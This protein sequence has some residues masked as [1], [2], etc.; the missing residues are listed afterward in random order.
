LKLFGRGSVS[1]DE[2]L[3]YIKGGIIVITLVYAI[4]RLPNLSE[5]AFQDYWRD[6]HGPLVAS[7]STALDISRYVQS[8]AILEN[9]ANVEVRNKNDGMLPIDGIEFYWWN[10]RDELANALATP[11]GKK[12]AKSLVEDEQKFIDFSHSTLFIGLEQIQIKGTDFSG[13]SP[14]NVV[15]IEKSHLMKGTCILYRNPK[16]FKSRQ[17][18]MLYYRGHHGPLVRSFE[19]VLRTRRY[20]Q[21][22]NIDDPLADELRAARGKMEEPPDCS[23]NA[24][25][26]RLHADQ[27]NATPEGMQA[28]NVIQEDEKEAFDQAHPTYYMMWTKEHCFVDRTGEFSPRQRKLLR[29]KGLASKG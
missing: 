17:E 12:A 3:K 10:S 24:W 26:H 8:H 6:Y 15:A 18:F 2:N 22:Q 25:I 20:S 9:P 27:A 5:E 13:S 11:E 4:R 7:Y 16:K 14:E 29:E 21:F 19:E 28:W 23:T 1:A